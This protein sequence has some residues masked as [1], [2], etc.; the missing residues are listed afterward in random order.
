M[1]TGII[2]G[3]V[4]FVLFS[5]IHD[6]A[7]ACLGGL[8][9][10]IIF[11][12]SRNIYYPMI[13]HFSTLTSVYLFT[14]WIN[15]FITRNLRTD[16]GITTNGVVLTIFV[17]GMALLVCGTILVCYRK[18]RMQENAGEMVKKVM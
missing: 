6:L 7:T 11:A 5:N 15:R 1:W 2:T 12:Y 13:A 10:G 8:V 3:A 18:N 16:L 4:V 9:Y 14:P 17:C